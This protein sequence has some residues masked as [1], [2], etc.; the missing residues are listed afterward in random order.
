M[1][2]SR[3]LIKFADLTIKIK[4]SNIVYSNA[5]LATTV[6]KG[7]RALLTVTWNYV[8]SKQWSLVV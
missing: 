3:F 1:A 2:I 4:E 5:V 6:E 7:G 8:L